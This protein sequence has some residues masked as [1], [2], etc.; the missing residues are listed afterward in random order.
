M[1]GTCANTHSSRLSELFDLGFVI[2]IPS[3]ALL[4]HAMFV[5]IKPRA[6]GNA[7]A[8]TRG[9]SRRLVRWPLPAPGEGER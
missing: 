4:R 6:D 3:G 7:D 5:E 8:Y 9:R 1:T 2:D